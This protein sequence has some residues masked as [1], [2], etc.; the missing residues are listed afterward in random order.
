VDD[1]HALLDDLIARG[2]NADC[3]EDRPAAWSDDALALRFTE[4]HEHDLRF[5]NLWGRWLIW[6]GQRWQT[7]ET[8]H[9]IEL[10]RH[11]AREASAE[12][13]DDKGPARLAASVASAKTV[14]AIER[15]ARVDRRHASVT[16]DWDADPWLLNTP[17]GTI[18]LQTGNMRRH[19]RADRITKMTAVAP[20]GACPA[21]APAAT[22]RACSSTPGPRSS[23]TTPRSP[24][25]RRSPPH[26]ANGTRPTLPCSAAPAP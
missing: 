10:G 8:Q 23:A 3:A 11:I 22:A 20:T 26:M 17:G 2:S 19:A 4:R 15:L 18:D 5:V 14:A 16:E 13:I 24:P 21:S 25:W 9:A 12:I 1:L 7:D 6:N